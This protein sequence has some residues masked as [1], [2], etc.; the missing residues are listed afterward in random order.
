MELVIPEALTYILATGFMGL[1]T[2]VLF[3]NIFSLP[4]NWIIL[5]FVALWKYIYPD[6][7]QMDVWFFVIIIALAVLGEV[8]ELALQV[9]KAK[10]Y[11]STSSGTFAGVVGAIV[12]AIVLA[13][14]FFGLGALIGA[15]IGAWLGCF[16]MEKLKGRSFQD[17][18]EAAFGAMVGRF[19]GTVCK[20]GVGGAMLAVIGRYIWPETPQAVQQVQHILQQ[21][22]A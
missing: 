13:P 4:A 2:L 5:G 11:G 15:L 18:R 8:L 6:T 17:A 3:L 14:L 1:L 12:G 20:C 22:I 10:K 9:V 7:A 19:L 16:I 21:F